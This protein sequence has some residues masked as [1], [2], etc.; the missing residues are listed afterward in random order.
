MNSAFIHGAA[1]SPSYFQCLCPKLIDPPAFFTQKL[2]NF[3]EPA[4]NRGRLL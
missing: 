4:V 3:A 1:S 2:A